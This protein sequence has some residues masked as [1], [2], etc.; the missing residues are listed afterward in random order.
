MQSKRDGCFAS[1][2]N[3]KVRSIWQSKQA[4]EIT[5]LKVFERSPGEPGL[6]K[7]VLYFF[8]TDLYVKRTLT[9]PGFSKTFGELP[10]S[11]RRLT[12][13]SKLKP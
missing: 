8:A 3:G 1:A 6:Y 13:G 4:F 7:S 2:G 9:R 10:Y 12:F 5:E 11:L